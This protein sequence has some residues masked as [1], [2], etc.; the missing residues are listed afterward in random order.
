MGKEWFSEARFGMFIHWGLYSV[1]QGIWKGR[2]I[3]RLSEWIMRFAEISAADY[4]TL[5]ASFN[6]GNFNADR[7]VELAAGAGMKYLVF[8]TKHHD[9]FSMFDTKYSDFSVTRAT[10][11]HR[12]VVAELADSC[13]RHGLKFCIYYSHRQ[14]WHE[15]DGVWKEWPGQFPVPPERRKPDLNRYLREKALPQ[16]RELLTRYG[17][18]GSVWFDTPQ[19]L[20]PEQSGAF[21]DLVHELQPDCLVNSRVGNGFEDYEVLGDNEFPYSFG[22]LNGEVP[23]TVNHSWGYKACD[24]DWKD[25]GTLIY[26]L[27]RSAANG[28]NYLLN[29][30]PD[31][32][33]NIP[34]ACAA[35]IRQIAKWMRINAEAIHGTR[36]IAFPVPP[37]GWMATA[38]DNRLHIFFEQ[39]PGSR[40]LLEGIR[41]RV[42]SATLLAAPE[43]KISW[44]QENGAILL[45]GLPAEAPDS[46]Y[47]VLKL[48]LDSEVRPETELR[49][50]RSGNIALTAG[51]AK[52]EGNADSPLHIS[53]KGTPENFRPG[54]GSLKW[55]FIIRTPGTYRLTALSARHWSKPWQDG[56]EVELDCA[57][58]TRRI[59]LKEGRILDNVQSS[60]HPET[61]SPL[62]TVHFDRPGH[63]T[64]R[65]SVTAMQAPQQGTV[66]EDMKN[67]ATLELISLKLQPLISGKEQE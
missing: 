27:I 36:G 34:E 64:L 4:E 26:S 6:P 35:R 61:E 50:N 3:P 49:Q 22:N 15:P 55:D 33:G 5:A 52:T 10:P 65:L 19:D 31:P 20:S 16:V 13:R 29:V 44:K 66:T 67:T 17:P 51:S 7:W 40:F 43:I 58:Q 14:D 53:R 38:K 56:T 25:A 46:F 47:P 54:T 42:L 57:G 11:F 28:C 63:Y 2:Q 21:A 37:E 45:D 48:E 1:A 8:T 9:G 23:A 24:T 32:D 59:L 60:Y 41:N 12:D 39:W 30:G 18:V 62:G